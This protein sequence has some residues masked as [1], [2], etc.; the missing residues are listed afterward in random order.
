[1]TLDFG[2][3]CE[4]ATSFSGPGVATELSSTFQKNSNRSSLD[5]HPPT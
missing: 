4:F 1:M 5:K 3:V 2:L